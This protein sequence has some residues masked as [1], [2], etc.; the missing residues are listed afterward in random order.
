MDNGIFMEGRKVDGS[1]LAQDCQ[2]AGVQ[3]AT[4][5]EHAGA[6]D[7]HGSDQWQQQQPWVRM[8]R[9]VKGES[10][11]HQTHDFRPQCGQ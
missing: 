6:A 9:Q 10:V 2:G 7:Q 3:G 5:A 4:S 11:Q 8:P 1:T